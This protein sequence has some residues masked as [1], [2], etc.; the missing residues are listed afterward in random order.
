MTAYDCPLTMTQLLKDRSTF[1]GE[2]KSK[3]RSIVEQL[4]K[5]FPSWDI[6]GQMEY[7]QLIKEQVRELLTD[8]RFLQTEEK[9]A[10]V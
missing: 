7:I 1:R 6:P 10:N 8:A 9:D 5:L 4:Y 2:I 3:A